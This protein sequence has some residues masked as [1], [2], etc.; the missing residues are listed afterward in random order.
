MSSTSSG[1]RKVRKYGEF[2]STSKASS[3]FD[4]AFSGPESKRKPERSLI[5]S[6]VYS[7]LPD[8]SLLPSVSDTTN[9]R[10][11]SPPQVFSPPISLPESTSTDG[12]AVEPDSNLD[13]SDTEQD[14]SP[15]FEKPCSSKM[16]TTASDSHK[17]ISSIVNEKSSNPFDFDEDDDLPLP[18][19]A[20]TEDEAP[21]NAGKFFAQKSSRPV[22]NHKWTELDDE[23]EEMKPPARTSGQTSV[24][25]SN[26]SSVTVFGKQQ[27]SKPLSRGAPVYSREG[28]SRV[29]N[30]K[31]AHQCLESGEHDDFKQ[32]LEYI[33]STM[34]AD[35]SLNIKC[36]SALSLAK[37]CVSSEFRQ[38]IRSEGQVAA[39]FK[40]MGEAPSDQ[41]FAI[42]AATII[43]L[44]SRDFI[45][46]PVDSQSLRLVCQLLR[47]EKIED[48][49]E[50]E[51]YKKMVWGVFEEYLKKM[52]SLG[53]KVV[54]DITFENISPSFLVME[55]LVF[56]LSRSPTEGFKTELLNLGALP[57]VVAKVEKVVLRLIHD[58]NLNQE[59]DSCL[60]ILERCFRILETSTFLHK[61]NQA[62]LVSHR[63]SVLIQTCGKLLPVIHS[64]IEAKAN[65]SKLTNRFMATLALMTRVLINMSHENELCSTKL[66]QM[67]GFLSLCLSSTTYLARK[68]GEED[69]KFDVNVLC[70]SLLVNL[71][72]RCDANR[73]KVIDSTVKV[74]LEDGEALESNG[75]D[76]LTKLFC[77]HESKARVV[78]E[79]L[80]QDLAFEEGTEDSEEE[81]NDEPENSGKLDRGKF[82]DMN[83]FE[84]LHAVQNAMNKA[85]SHMEDS[86]AA[87]YLALLIGCLLQQNEEYVDL[88]KEHLPNKSLSIVIEQ[89]HRFLE[90][91]KISAKKSNGWRSVEKIADL[92]ETLN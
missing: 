78:D 33:M 27:Q 48:N 55:A 73:R 4:A 49:S 41:N 45:P 5:T 63:A 25:R 12:G 6:R 7:Q 42:C 59:I 61:K 47:I 71:V 30:V 14:Y 65:D 54:F 44:M 20:K 39:I 92:L 74:H 58:K 21:T 43:Y 23:E 40:N 81:T 15:L 38:F 3:L 18:K 91:M 17:S 66:G 50:Q 90:F 34:K 69:K 75:L 57:W 52:E 19:K 13:C 32:D 62:F 11:T 83:E 80:D 82:D 72:E 9:I 29:R 86:V 26:S 8:D 22:Y 85:S 56:V 46:F 76:A 64:S 31:D 24:Y 60:I 53:K 89:L 70:C 87:S 77:I 2:S 88:V 1:Q 28:S 67:P 37:K 51:K 36:L 79:E 16:F 10:R 35:S 68:F 84:M